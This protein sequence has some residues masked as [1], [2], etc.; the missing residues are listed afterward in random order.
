[1]S[2]F[3]PAERRSYHDLR[4]RI[5]TGIREN[6]P[7]RLG[8]LAR[9]ADASPPGEIAEWL[10]LERRCCPFLDVALELRHDRSLWIRVE[11]PPKSKAFLA[12]EFVEFLTR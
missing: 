8:F 5:A 1:M 11:G 4:G 12:E 10:V 3:T 2:A 6:V 9:I 7:T